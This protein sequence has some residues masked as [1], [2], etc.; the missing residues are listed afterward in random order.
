LVK[1]IRNKRRLAIS[2]E[3]LLK[4]H[5]LMEFYLADSSTEVISNVPAYSFWHLL[6]D[7]GG[8]M[9]LFLGASIF[10]FFAF[11]KATIVKIY[12]NS[13]QRVT[14]CL[15]VKNILVPDFK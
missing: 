12:H 2:A 6:S 4:N 14:F 1:Q 9:G 11:F 5:V 7:I 15:C 8:V 13:Q 3:Y 10:S